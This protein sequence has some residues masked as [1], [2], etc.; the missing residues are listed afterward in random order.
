MCLKQK[1][2]FLQKKRTM[3]KVQASF[4]RLTFVFA[5]FFFTN[6]VYAQ[7]SD[8]FDLE[9]GVLS[10]KVD[11]KISLYLSGKY[12]YWFNPTVG[13]TIGGM[14]LHSNIDKRFESPKDKNK[15]YYIDDNIFNLNC[16]TGLKLSSPTY[17]NLGIMAD[18]NFLFEPIPFNSVSIKVVN[19]GDEE[20]K[21]KF[22]FTRFNPSYQLQASL[23]YNIKKQ[24][25]KIMQISLGTG[26][27]NYNPY[28]T[29]YRSTIDNIKLKNQLSLSSSKIGYTVFLRLSGLNL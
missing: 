22:V 21:N 9:G 19:A 26:I 29:Y 18:L 5:L 11:D 25:K 15:A 4:A 6:S 7:T 3:S 14:F 12:N 27:S 20:S 24:N 23:F 10:S 8:G 16:I 2:V 17:K 28:N 1:R 13:V